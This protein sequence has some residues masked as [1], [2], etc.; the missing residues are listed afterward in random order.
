MDIKKKKTIILIFIIIVFAIFLVLMK[1]L[2]KKENNNGNNDSVN[3]ADRYTYNL[4][5]TLDLEEDSGVEEI[6]EESTEYPSLGIRNDYFDTDIEMNYYEDKVTFQNYEGNI[7]ISSSWMDEGVAKKIK[8]PDFG[9]IEKFMLKNSS[10]SARFS[11]VNMKQVITYIN[12]LSGMGFNN[13]KLDNKNKKN[14]TYYYVATNSED[15]SVVLN[16]ESGYFY[17]EVNDPNN[18]W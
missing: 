9:N 17:I 11:D 2:L 13:I 6:V 18:I 15:I 8:E 10:I 16:Y 7:T 5:E 1:N 3:P 14:D 4:G 12:E